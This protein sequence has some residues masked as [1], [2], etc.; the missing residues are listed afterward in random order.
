MAA[1]R[2]CRPKTRQSSNHPTRRFDP[3]NGAVTR[4]RPARPLFALT[5]CEARMA[6]TGGWRTLG[7]RRKT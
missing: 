4:A 3:M 5:R 1:N 7:L 2:Y 6:V